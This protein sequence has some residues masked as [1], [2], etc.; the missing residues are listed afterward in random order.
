MTEN[1]SWLSLVCHRYSC[2]F[3]PVCIYFAYIDAKFSRKPVLAGVRTLIARELTRKE[4]MA[5]TKFFFSLFWWIELNGNY[6]KKKKNLS[7]K[8]HGGKVV[9]SVHG[10]DDVRN[11]KWV[12]QAADDFGNRIVM[13]SA[14]WQYS[15][16]KL[17]P[18]ITKRRKSLWMRIASDQSK[19]SS[20]PLIALHQSA[21]R[22]SYALHTNN[23][24]YAVIEED[25]GPMC[26]VCV[27]MCAIKIITNVVRDVYVFTIALSWMWLAQCDFGWTSSLEIRI[28]IVIF[29]LYLRFFCSF[30]VNRLLLWHRMGR[31]KVLTTLTSLT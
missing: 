17:S 5:E 12:S 29:I 16:V 21:I 2:L 4:E 26:N 14:K 19:R 13:L 31:K 10:V 30:F 28:A 6:V 20:S 15:M 3:F 25:P 7:L 22:G 23:Y 18:M 9:N 1:D 27:R 8:M 11:G 24:L